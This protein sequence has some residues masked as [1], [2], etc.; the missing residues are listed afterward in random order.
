MNPFHIKSIFKLEKV[1]K[2]KLLDLSLQSNSPPPPLTME[3]IETQS[4]IQ[5]SFDKY[6]MRGAIYSR[7]CLFDKHTIAATFQKGAKAEV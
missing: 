6:V 2:K 7:L 4:T 5:I 3:T 1:Y